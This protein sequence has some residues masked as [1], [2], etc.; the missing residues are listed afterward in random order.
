MALLSVRRGAVGTR[1]VVTQRLGTLPWTYGI[2]G[3]R[4]CQAF[5]NY[6]DEPGSRDVGKRCLPPTSRLPDS[7]EARM[8]F[9]NR[10]R[11]QAQGR[12]P[13]GEAFKHAVMDAYGFTD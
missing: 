2:I 3:V 8:S 10:F 6:S 9:L 1:F 5:R 4:R 12:Y 7:Q 13:N 11:P